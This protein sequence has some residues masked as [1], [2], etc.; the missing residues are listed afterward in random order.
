M[1]KQG[2]AGSTPVF[3]SLATFSLLWENDWTQLKAFSLS[4]AFCLNSI[5]RCSISFPL[6]L[7]PWTFVRKKE[8]PGFPALHIFPWSSF[9]WTLH[10]SISSLQS[11]HSVHEKHFSPKKCLSSTSSQFWPSKFLW[12]KRWVHPVPKTMYITL[13]SKQALDTSSLHRTQNMS[14]YTV[15]HH[16][17]DEQRHESYIIAFERQI[18]L[19]SNEIVYFFS[20]Q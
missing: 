7:F 10:S 16:S 2:K 4:L 3:W 9:Q 8:I 19:L 17:S 13:H 6:Y 12:N 18:T 14:W 1:R 5:T 15:V 20:S 11:L